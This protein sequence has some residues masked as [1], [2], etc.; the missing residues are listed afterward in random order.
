MARE[1]HDTL[2]QGLAGLVLQLE[3]ADSH[4]SSQNHERAQQIVQQAMQRARTTLADAR[5][6]IDNLR[7]ETSTAGDLAAAL[8]AEAQLFENLTGA[9]CSLEISLPD[10]IPA[11]VGMHALRTV[12]EGLSNIARHAQAKH[13]WVCLIHDDRFLQV[14][15]RDDGVGLPQDAD[16][17]GS[18]H[19][20]LLG[21]RERARLAGGTFEYSSQ[22]G[23]GTTLILRLPL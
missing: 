14:T 4:L 23:A 5:K 10:T 1:L 18:G 7:A 21:M 2:A 19:Y 6:A 15:V 9:D 8:H 22:A 17:M 11:A 16:R 20:G 12:S 3:A 13:A